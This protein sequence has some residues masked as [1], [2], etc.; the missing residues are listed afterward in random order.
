MKTSEAPT[1]I[2]V[3]CVDDHQIIR[4]GISLIINLQA[5]MEVV[6]TAATPEQSI[7][8]FHTHQPDVT[9]MDLRFAVGSGI[10]A[11]RSI[12][13][14]FPNARIIALTMYQSVEAIDEALKA[15][16]ATYVSKDTS[17]E[18]LVRCIREVHAG[19]RPLASDVQT[20]LAERGAQA[21]LT[22]REIEVIDLVS[23]GFRNKE[24]AAYLGIREETVEVHLRN[25]FTKM[26]VNDRTAAVRVALHRGIIQMS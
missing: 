19:H 4:E 25:I 11:I 22:H 8:L 13:H 20:R 7:A 6:G 14:E 1:K 9:L 18:D 12:V 26:K 24:I 23:Q 3:L 2:R 10:D 15:G 21:L 17:S 5:D 16:A